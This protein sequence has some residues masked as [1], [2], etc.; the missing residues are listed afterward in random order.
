MSTIKRPILLEIDGV[1]GRLQDGDIINAGGVENS[2]GTFTVNGVG[3]LFDDGTSSAP[4]GGSGNITLQKIYDL[5]PAVGG[6]AKI[7]L[8]TG[9]DFAI[10]DDTDSS[11]YFRIDS[12]TGKVTITGDLE[13]LGES[14]IINTIIQDSDHWLISPKSGTTT[15]LRIEPDIG[16][17]PIVDVVT[18]RNIFGGAPVFRIDKD[19]NVILSQ[20]LTVA[21]TINGVNVVQLKSDLDAHL[22]GDPGYRHLAADV[23]ILPIATLPGAQNV[24]QALEMI[25][26]KADFGSGGNTGDSYGYEHVQA[27]ANTSWFI[28]HNGMTMR[29]Q[30]TVYDDDWEQIIPDKVKIVDANNILVTF[31]SPITG[32]AMVIMF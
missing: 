19:G 27:V 3:L 30:V 28:G 25:N 2:S 32:R 13:V 1:L 15:A 22:A 4:G 14:T 9:K 17:V 20:N 21:G 8:S 29:C 24:Q 7:Q 18:I 16:V 5:S 12:E 6:A 11:V 26:Q 10:I 31:S 23:D